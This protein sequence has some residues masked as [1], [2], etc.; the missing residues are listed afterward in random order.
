MSVLRFAFTNAVLQQDI[1]DPDEDTLAGQMAAMR[2]QKVKR[3]PDYDE[4]EEDDSDS[5]SESGQSDY[6][7]TTTESE[8]E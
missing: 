6:S 2:G 1:S 7:G 5:A 3:I 4:E 8:D